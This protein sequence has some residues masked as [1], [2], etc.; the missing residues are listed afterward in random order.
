M[1]S[2][3][4]TGLLEPIRSMLRW[5]PCRRQMSAKAAA[6]YRTDSTDRRNAL[7]G[8][9]SKVR[10]WSTM[11]QPTRQR[12]KQSITVARYRTPPSPTGMQV[13]SPVQRLPVKQF[14]FDALEERSGEGVVVRT[15]CWRTRGE[16]EPEQVRHGAGG[17]LGHGGDLALAQRQPGD[18]VPA[19]DPPDALAVHALARLA[20]LGGDT[21]LAIG[22][23]PL[24]MHGA[25]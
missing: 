12:E 21:G 2:V 25:L 16:V 3:Q 9:R 7:I 15:G 22:G 23:V 17:R 1:A 8:R 6:L 11:G 13:M 20:E 5:M 24:G 14:S 18:A 4:P 10:M 19:H